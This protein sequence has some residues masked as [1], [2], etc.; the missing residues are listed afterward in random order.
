MCYYT[1]KLDRW[2][3]PMVAVGVML[4]V[5]LPSRSPALAGMVVTCPQ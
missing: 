4:S 3:L 5:F 2:L 1:Q